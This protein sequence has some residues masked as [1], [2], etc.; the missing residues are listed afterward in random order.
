ML[1]LSHGKEAYF[2]DYKEM[3]FKLY[4]ELAQITER[5]IE[6]QRKYEGIYISDDENASE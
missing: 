6:L 3:Y 5:L 1:G 2:M 4:G